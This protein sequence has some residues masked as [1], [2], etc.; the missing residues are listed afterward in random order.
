[1]FKKHEVIAFIGG[2]PPWGTTSSGAGIES[3]G[4]LQTSGIGGDSEPLARLVQKIS[5][6]WCAA[7]VAQP[8]FCESLTH[9]AQQ[10]VWEARCALRIVPINTRKPLYK[11]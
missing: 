6:D 1:V 7:H 9:V 2:Q 5:F 10:F 4:S 3:T 8:R 11:K